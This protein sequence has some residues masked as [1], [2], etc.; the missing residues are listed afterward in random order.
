MNEEDNEIHQS[1]PAWL[2]EWKD[3]WES[4]RYEYREKHGLLTLM[5]R[6]C[7]QYMDREDQ[8]AERPETSEN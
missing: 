2:A 3:D 4:F 8:E 7:R 5:E 1:V 6:S